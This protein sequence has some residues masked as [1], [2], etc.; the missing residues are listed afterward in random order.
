MEP[1]DG[2]HDEEEQLWQG[3]RAFQAVVGCPGRERLQ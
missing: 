3:I 1:G 2:Q